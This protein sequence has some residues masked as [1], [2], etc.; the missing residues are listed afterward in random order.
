[1]L[2]YRWPGNVRQLQSVVTSAVLVCGL[3]GSQKIAKRHIEP[4]LLPQST[5]HEGSSRDIFKTLAETELRMAENALIRSGGKKGEAWKLLKYKNRFTMLR[6]VK[7]I[8]SEHPE[9]A[10]RFPEL[11]KSYS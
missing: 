9:L 4:L 11:K 7:R 2:N 8:I 1:M 3:E 10:E 6:R 5:P